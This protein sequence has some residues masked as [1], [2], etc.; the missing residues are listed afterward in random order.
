MNN[1]CTLFDTNYL[2]RGL[3]LYKS[4]K[5]VCESFHL[6]IFAFDAECFD[7]L[8]KLELE[9]ATIIPLS[10]FED[11]DLLKIK[12][13][14]NST[15]YCWTS[16][17]STILFVLKNF[18]VESCTYLD[19]DLFFYSSPQ[20]VFDELNS[21]SILLTEH[22]YSKVYKKEIENSG[23]YCVQFI[24]FK[25]NKEGLEALTWWRNKCLEWCYDRIEDGK[26]GDQMYLND[27]KERFPGV[28]V[29]QH[30]GGGIA[31]WN[32]SRYNFRVISNILYGFEKLSENKFP[33]VFYHFHNLKFYT[34]G[35][36]ELGPRIISKD[37]INIFY[38]PYIITLLQIEKE[39]LKIN[40]S[41]NPNGVTKKKLIIKSPLTFIKRKLFKTHHVYNLKRFLER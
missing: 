5:E 4:L 31:G 1:F 35:Q 26:F 13:T 3:A 8:K 36:I 39:I 9:D 7:T 14:R 15:E 11:E 19:A 28:H 33:V 10:Q 18:N 22:R 37:A 2:T 38:K 41:I 16:T 27:W 20:I 24:T 25:N 29:L 30:L 17:P 6:Y 23:K 34:N 21:N 40:P 12:P 32:V